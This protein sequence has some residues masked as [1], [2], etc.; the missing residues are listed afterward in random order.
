MTIVVV[1][2]NGDDAHETDSRPDSKQASNQHDAPPPVFSKTDDLPCCRT[3]QQ[4]MLSNG[5]ARSPE[6]QREDGRMGT[7]RETDA[8]RGTRPIGGNAAA[9]R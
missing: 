6:E 2:V 8:G 3:T 5:D 7:L 1:M 4:Q 9:G